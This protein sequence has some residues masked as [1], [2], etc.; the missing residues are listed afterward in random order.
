VL[1]IAGLGNP[2]PRYEATRHNVGFRVV[3]RWVERHGNASWRDKFEGQV[4]SVD[5]D[6]GERVLVLKPMTFMNLSGHSVRAA[7]AFYKI[8]PTSLVLVHDE[9]DLPFGEFRLKL[10]GG[11][12]GH[13]GVGSV[14]E[15][16]GTDGFARLRFGIGRAPAEF[17]GSGADFVLESFPLA[18]RASLNEL[19]D[20]SSKVLDQVVKDG[21]SAAMNQANRRKK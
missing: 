11:D 20:A 4:A 3:D 16:L 5:C 1:L 8:A 12:A 9:L 6:N 7:L 14:I 13:N 18:D 17:V 15:Q 21:V 10:G 2:G 19:I